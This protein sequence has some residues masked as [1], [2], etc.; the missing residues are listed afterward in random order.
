MN[1]RVLLREL[2]PPLVVRAARKLRGRG[3]NS[4]TEWEFFPAGFAGASDHRVRGWNEVSVLE[5]YRKRFERER[6]KCEEGVPFG[7]ERA[8]QETDEGA[9]IMSNVALSF[10]TTLGLVA[11]REGSLSV[12]DWGGG[13]G[14]Y[15]LWGRALRPDLEF[16]YTVKEMPLFLEAGRELWQGENVS[17]DDGNACLSRKYDLTMAVCSLHYSSDWKSDFERLV[18]VT[19]AKIF[20]SRLPVCLRGESYPFIQRP[21]A[22]GYETE[23]IGWCLNRE[24]FL[25]VAQN[26]GLRLE[27]EFVGGER[28]PIQN[29]PSPCEYRGFVFGL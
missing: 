1:A 21:Y 11:Q 12:L 25:E 4:V 8:G 5:S 20:V 29:A 15:L 9:V 17:F 18:R 2:V 28:P 19:R 23:Y 7:L 16:D 10:G 3:R 24:E 13:L 26:L 22:Y 14:H 6:R 27:R